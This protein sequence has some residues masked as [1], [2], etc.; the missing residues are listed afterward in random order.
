MGDFNG[1]SSLWG[2]KDTNSRGRQIEKMIEDHSLCL[3]NN[4]QETYFHGPTI[5]FHALDLAICSRSLLPFCTYSVGDDL[6]NS[7]HFPI[8]VTFKREGMNFVIRPSRFIFER[9]DW[10][11]FYSLAQFTEE[12]VN[13]MPVENAVKAVT[14]IIIQAAIASIPLTSPKPPKYPKPWWN[15]KC[16]ETLREQRKSCRRF[17]KCPTLSNV[18]AFKKAKAS[19]RK[20]KKNVISPCQSGF[21]K[22]RTTV[23]NMVLLETSIR[24]AFVKRN[25]L[26]SVFFD[27]EKAY[28]K[29]WTHGILLDLHTFGLRGNLP[30]FLRNFLKDRTFKVK[31]GSV[32]SDIFSQ[33]EGVPQ[34]CVLSV[35]LFSLKIN[36]VLE[37]LPPTVSGSLYVDDLQISCQGADMR[38]VERQL[39]IAL[40]KI[41]PWSKKEGFSFLKQKTV[42][43]HFC[44]KRNLHPEPELHLGDSMIPVEPEVKF[45]GVMFDRKLTFLSHILYLR[46]KCLKRLNLLKVLANTSWG[47]DRA[48]LLRIYRALIG[49]KLDYGSVVYGSA[50]PSML[51]KLD[52]VHHQALRICSGAFRTSPVQS[53][54]VDC[55]EPSLQLRREQ[56][57]LGYYFHV[58]SLPDHLN[59]VKFI[60]GSYKFLFEARPSHVPYFSLRVNSLIEKYHMTDLTTQPLKL[61]EI[62]PWENAKIRLLDIFQHFS[63][64]DTNEFVYRQ[65]FSDHKHK[66]KSY[67]PVYTD[68]SKAAGHVGASFIVE[69]H[70]EGKRLHDA[71]SVFTSELSALYYALLFISKVHKR[72]FIIYTDSFSALKSLGSCYSAKNPIVT[73]ILSLNLKLRSRCYDILYC[74]VPGH[75]DIKGN[76]LA[77]I[78]AKSAVHLT[79]Q[80][81]PINDIRDVIKQGIS[82]KL[83]QLWDLQRDTKLKSIK[84]KIER[85]EP[86]KNRKEEVLLTRL[87]IGHSGITHNYLLKAESE[88]MCSHCNAAI[89]SVHHFLVDCS[90]F[91]ELRLKHFNS[92]DLPLDHI[93]GKEVNSN[94]FHYLKETGIDLYISSL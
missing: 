94:L 55:H 30:I 37:K 45:L 63:K 14:D 92:C 41:V 39:Q 85:W 8:F 87:R 2:N 9:A 34:G 75:M 22:G 28:Y 73:D 80:L 36:S 7:D 88:P 21:R 49:S 6:H 59:H 64:E 71:C 78:M 51:L 26:V 15:H 79:D 29:A 31:I 1:H 54:Y 82:N 32:V 12:D 23:D 11:L 70:M 77:D 46:E 58:L 76:Q 60:D 53:L 91:K 74:W 52:P 38:Y 47:A 3:L 56:L 67:I 81:V 48:S 90:Y 18:I 25:H 61:F 69:D 89:M 13:D 27:I 20:E 43:V 24:K 72:Q 16:Q 33:E 65:L 42:C 40:N 17:R 44:R 66:Y 57:S 50:R 5:T 10:E 93:I 68:G 35:T 4:G 62:S 86:T 84:T 19:A 83:Q